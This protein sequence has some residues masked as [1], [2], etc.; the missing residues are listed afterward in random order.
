MK[1]EDYGLIGDTQTC[2]LVS[3]SGSVDWMCVPR[4]DAGA[5]FAALLGGEEHGFWRIGPASAPRS[6]TR[7]YR[8]DSLVLETDFETDGGLLRLT[9]CMPIRQE[10]PWLV[11]LARCVRGEVAVRMKLVIRFNYGET[12]PWVRRADHSLEAK[13][14]PDALILRTR[15]Q[16]RGEGFATVADFT[17]REGEKMPFGLHWYPSHR[18]PPA[19]SRVE[20]AIE[21]TARWWRRW[22]RR[23]AYRGRYPGAVRTSLMAVKALTYAPTGG[24]VAAPTT[25]LP[26]LIGGG[27]NWDYRFCWLRDASFT[28]DALLSAGF[29]A[30]AAAWSDWLLRAIAGDAADL[31]TLYG[32]A[33]ERTV[34]EFEL[35]HLPGYE[36]SR[37][38]RVGNAA[39]RQFQLDVYGEVINALGRARVSRSGVRSGGLDAWSLQRKLLEFVSANW[40]RDDCGIWEVRGGEKSFT[41]SKA[42][43]WVALDRSV[44]MAEKFRLPAELGR[45]RR[46]R[47]QIRGDV[48]ARGFNR[49]VG[50]FTQSYGSDRLDASVLR[51]P[52]V[53]FLPARDR[54]MVSTVR[55]IERGLLADGLVLRYSPGTDNLAGGEGA[56]LPCSFWLADNYTLSG[57]RRDARALFER[58]LGLGNDLG[59]FSEEYDPSARRMLGNFPQAFTQVAVVNSAIQLESP[60]KERARRGRY[61]GGRR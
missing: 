38:V 6:V 25:S 46:L 37:P 54:R 8:G 30:E 13:A 24:I 1:I 58:L 33:G 45:W 42:M 32:T 31:Q 19:P 23:C 50:A 35:D 11:R 7:R 43:A 15:A 26:E 29:A 20:E 16:T 51:L 49:R 10:Y 48:L 5:C 2:A 40:T 36:G 3:R 60:P 57:R 27:R 39:S 34:P 47:A 22:M 9:D 17:L 52:L 14:G 12:L 59:L 44:K 55:A 41:Y 61:G 28:L 18:Q 56:F 53:G 21:R 4:F